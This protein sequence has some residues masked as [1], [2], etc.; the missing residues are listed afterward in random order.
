MSYHVILIMFIIGGILGGVLAIASKVFKVEVDE[1]EEKVTSL[2]PG[3][4]C[5]ACGFAGC[6]GLAHGLV[7]KEV[8]NF[9]CKI[10]KEDKKQE[11]IDYLKN[12][13]GP[14]G[15]TIEIK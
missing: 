6:S 11:I 9:A 10:C 3:Y 12:T 7:S 15:S 14:D 5:G 1:R 8:S 13:P 2:L 4:N